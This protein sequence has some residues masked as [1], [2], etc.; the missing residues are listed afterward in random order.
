MEEIEDGEPTS[1]SSTIAYTRE[2]DL[3]RFMSVNP[4]QF[5]SSSRQQQQQEQEQQEEKD[6]FRD[7]REIDNDRSLSFQ[8]KMIRLTTPQHDNEASSSIIN[9]IF[10]SFKS[11]SDQGNIPNY[12]DS[13][14]CFLSIV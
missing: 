12:K 14:F 4:Q 2:S 11:C 9:Q 6:I 1:Q 10:A 5:V 8:D 7:F 13:L 3:Q